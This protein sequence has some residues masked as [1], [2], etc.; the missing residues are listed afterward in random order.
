M[1][2]LTGGLLVLLC[3]GGVG[4]FVVLYD[5]AT[6]IKRTEP[7]AVVDS[8]LAAFLVTRDDQETALYQCKAGGDLSQ[9]NEFR[10]DTLS[11]ETEHSVKISISWSSLDVNVN[12]GSGTVS[13]DLTRT[14][15][16]QGGR[17]SSSWQFAVI[18]QDGWRVCGATRTY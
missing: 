14:I 15:S 3:V 7:D 1:L 16:G 13:A 12:G 6:E 5:E 4:A 17:D 8:F 9:I 18:D 11:R 2:A 10:S